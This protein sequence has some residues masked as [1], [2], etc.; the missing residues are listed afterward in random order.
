MRKEKPMKLEGGYVVVIGGNSGIGLA[1]A[2]LARDEGAEVTIAGRSQEKLL[3]AQQELGKVYTGVKD[4]TDEN[5][6][7]SANLLHG[8]ERFKALG[9][10]W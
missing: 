7:V 1:A 6:G 3:Q 5:A 8:F 10:F 4:I 2:R 9:P